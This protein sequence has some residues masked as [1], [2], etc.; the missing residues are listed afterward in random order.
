MPRLAT[1][2]HA[3][4]RRVAHKT[5]EVN[6]LEPGQFVN[7]QAAVSLFPEGR[8]VVVQLALHDWRFTV[9]SEESAVVWADKLTKMAAMC[10]AALDA[11][12]HK[13]D[14]KVV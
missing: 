8:D 9:E 11:I 1:I 14:G 7:L 2:P 13:L 3:P 4:I 5:G 6:I 10:H 12:E